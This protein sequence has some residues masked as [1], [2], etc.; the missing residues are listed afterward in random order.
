MSKTLVEDVRSKAMNV[1]KAEIIKIGNS[2]GVRIPEP[3]IRQ[4]GLGRVEIAVQ[5]KRLV[6]RPLARPRSG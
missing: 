3:M 5:K 1:V 4:L 6:I 2:H